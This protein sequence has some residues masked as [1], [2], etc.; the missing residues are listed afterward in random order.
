VTIY[1]ASVHVDEG[2]LHTS[3]PILAP[4]PVGELIE[5]VL[6]DVRGGDGSIVSVD[7]VIETS[8]ESETPIGDATAG[9]SSTPLP[10]S[11]GGG[12][13]EGDEPLDDGEHTAPPLPP[14]TS[15]VPL[16]PPVAGGRS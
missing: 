14:A 15:P 11:D 16:L 5:S 6:Y 13:V 9:T 3:R 2:M 10:D 4:D 12:Q 7:V 8:G 1:R